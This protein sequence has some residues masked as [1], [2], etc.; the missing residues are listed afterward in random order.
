MT[1]GSGIGSAIS[2]CKVVLFVPDT[3]LKQILLVPDVWASYFGYFRDKNEEEI[4]IGLVNLYST[5]KSKF[6]AVWIPEEGLA[7]AG[8]EGR[9]PR[10]GER[11]ILTPTIP[12]QG[13][14]SYQA[15]RAAEQAIMETHGG[16]MVGRVRLFEVL[17]GIGDADGNL[18]VI[19]EALKQMGVSGVTLS[20]LSKFPFLRT[21]NDCSQTICLM[22]LER[23]RSRFSHYFFAPSLQRQRSYST[24]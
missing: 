17:K 7:K 12:L 24:L 15:A 13:S 9:G 6:G 22:V 21:R 20:D 11:Q 3:Q 5:L 19:M 14:T 18:L 10:E 8:K 16:T 23:N 1:G 4:A 2:R